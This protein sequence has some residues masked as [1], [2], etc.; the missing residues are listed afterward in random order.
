VD[1]IVMAAGEGRRLRPLTE[2]WAKPILPID[3]RPVLGT[4]LRELAAAGVERATIVTGHLAVQ[5]EAFL[6]DG[7]W[8]VELSFARQPRPDGSADA[9]QRALDAG[10][11]LPA[12]VTA[13]DT[14]YTQGDVARFADVF[15]TSDAAGALAYR[16]G[17]TPSKAKPGVRVEGTNV[18]SVY[19]LDPGNPFTSAPLWVLDEPVRPYLRGL[20]G[21]PYELKDAY[22]PAIDDGLAIV[23]FEIGNT[24]DLTDPLDLVEENFPYLSATTTT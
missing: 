23:G 7:S 22:Q 17:H 6:D 13:A 11:R 21:P 4:L 24:R 1:A 9:V 18:A 5:V 19:D 14:V 2:R 16:R 3:G 12:L 20:P 8:A 10:A 15:T